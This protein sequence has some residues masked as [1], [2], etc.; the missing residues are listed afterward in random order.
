MAM[1]IDRHHPTCANRAVVLG[2][3]INESADVYHAQSDKYLSSHQLA[4]FRKC[5]RLYRQKKLGQ[6]PDQ[7]G[8]SFLVGRAAHVAILEGEDRFAAEFAVGGPIN[9]RTGQPF[10]QGTKA[11]TEWAEAQAKTVL[12]NDQHDLVRELAASVRRHD[13]ASNLLRDG[14]AE[15]VVRTDYLGIACQARLDW[16]APNHGLVDLKTCDDLTWFEADA[17]RFGY[18][19]QL[20]FYRA[21]AYLAAGELLPVH[22]IAVEKKPPFRCGVWR[23]EPEIL[24]HA[25]IA[26]ERAM[27]RLLI[28]QRDDVWPTGYEDV[29]VFDQL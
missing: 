24:S 29:R 28:C 4:D 8:S 26:N 10:G 23:V 9:P 19:F 5:P 16:V 11:W 25:Q 2:L 17:R 21:L 6:I 7:E 13:V 15:G 1:T 20:A 14:V 22:L 3:L 27:Q 12:T 18:V